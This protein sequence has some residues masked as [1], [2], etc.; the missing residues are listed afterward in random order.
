MPST[1]RAE[2]RDASPAVRRRDHST[3]STESA[4]PGH[5]LL[6]LQRQVGNAQIARLMAHREAMPEEEQLMAMHIDRDADAGASIMPEVGMEGGQISDSLSQRIESKRGGGSALDSA[7]RTSMESA[8]GD[9]FD[10]VRIHQ[11]H[12]SDQLNRA[13]SAKAF[14]TGT[15][16]FLSQQASAGDSHLLAHELTHV[17]QQRGMSSSGG[18]MTVGAADSGHEH[19]ASSMASAVT[20]GAASAGV[21]RCGAG[22]EEVARE[23]VD[24][25]ELV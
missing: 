20:S 15:D 8:L 5:P 9:K 23:A 13:I 12:E 21:Q 3:Q 24:D 17:V 16:I 25:D 2:V 6:K 18:P 22:Q 19:E 1:A 4:V 7:T 14:T 10:D 11:D